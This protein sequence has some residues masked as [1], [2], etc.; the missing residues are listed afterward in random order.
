MKPFN[1]TKNNFFLSLVLVLSI[2]SAKSQCGFDIN[3][4]QTNNG[5][6]QLNSGSLVASVSGVIANPVFE[7]RDENGTVISTNN[8]INSLPSGAYI[9]Y[10]LDSGI[11]CTQYKTAIVKSYYESIDVKTQ[12][13][14]CPTCTDGI[15]ELYFEGGVA[16][17]EYFWDDEFY[18]RTRVASDLFANTYSVLLLDSNICEASQTIDINNCGE[19]LTAAFDVNQISCSSCNDASIEIAVSGGQ[20]PYTYQWNDNAFQTDSIAVNLNWQQNYEV[21]VVD[22]IGCEKVFSVDSSAF[23]EASIFPSILTIGLPSCYTCIDDSVAVFV[24]GTFNTNVSYDWIGTGNTSNEIGGVPSD[25]YTVQITD[26]IG[27]KINY[28]VDLRYCYGNVMLEIDSFNLTNEYIVNE[29]VSLNDNV[30]ALVKLSYVVSKKAEKGIVNMSED[31]SFTY[32]PYKTYS[33]LDEFSYQTFSDCGFSEEIMVYLELDNEDMVWPGDVNKDGI[34]DNFDLLPIGVSFDSL[35]VVRT[36]ASTDYYGQFANDWFVNQISGADLKH[37]DGDGSGKI[38]DLDAVVVKD[39]YGVVHSFVDTTQV[40]NIPLVIKYPEVINAGDTVEFLISLGDSDILATDVYGLAF[41]FNIENDIIRKD[42]VD[43]K[44]NDSWFTPDV[45]RV[46]LYQDFLE[47]GRID[48]AQ[49][50]INQ[51]NITGSGDICSIIIV[52]IDDVDE[53]IES[54]LFGL[55]SIRLIQNNEQELYVNK[56]S[57][58]IE[59]VSALENVENDFN[60]GMSPNPT[61]GKVEISF[62]K[63]SDYDISILNVLG[64][65]VYEESFEKESTVNL[66]LDLP[67]GFYFMNVSNE[68]L[69]STQKIIISK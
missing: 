35:G 38:T 7:W 31:G 42:F 60:F 52:I 13:V 30:N 43:V 25:V 61:N 15:A 14:S 58:I 20:A 12:N 65:V 59:V 9:V 56:K 62:N 22:N 54:N 17:Y 8:S 10:V 23:C 32:K 33:G 27:C 34:V 1:L 40:G 37:V 49:S 21:I 2:F 16:D 5:C 44:F 6:N 26:S 36:G 55:N 4:A 68:G 39:N 57:E 46:A 66:K 45:N 69:K 64:N 28:S 67:S 50:R 47:K 11:S 48:V 24:N 41:T 18:Q 51:A 19:N 29:N 3:I 53:K 63:R